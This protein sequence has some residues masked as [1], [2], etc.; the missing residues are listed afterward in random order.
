MGMGLDTSSHFL[1]R[2]EQCGLSE[3]THPDAFSSMR[4]GDLIL[5][6]IFESIRDSEPHYFFLEAALDLPFSNSR[7]FFSSFCVNG[8]SVPTSS[9]P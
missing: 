5:L 9:V 2:H 7:I 3:N 4:L 6:F 1:V 8:T